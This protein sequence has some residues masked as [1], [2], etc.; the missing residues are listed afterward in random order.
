[1]SLN[2]DPR[3]QAQEVIF[4]H[5]SMRASQPPLVFNNNVSQTFSQKY[6]GEHLNNVL[7]KLKL[8]KQ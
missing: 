3:K 7:A 6:L 5:K 8:T 1:M 4:S 2:H